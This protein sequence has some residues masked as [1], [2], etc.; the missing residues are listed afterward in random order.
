DL[1]GL[2]SNALFKKNRLGTILND[3]GRRN[4]RRPM[5]R[6]LGEVQSY[7]GVS[8]S[9]AWTQVLAERHRRRTRKRGA[10][11]RVA[12]PF[13]RRSHRT[14]FFGTK[15]SQP[16]TCP[17]ARRPRVG[18]YHPPPLPPTDRARDITRI[19]RKARGPFGGRLA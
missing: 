17:Y 12:P 5:R 6:Q 18:A 2:S 1:F 15:N 14:R 3:D 10:S 7:H 16:G 9:N 11:H 8:H 13:G 4:P 19:S